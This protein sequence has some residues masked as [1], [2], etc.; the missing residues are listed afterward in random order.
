MRIP[1]QRWGTWHPHSLL[2]EQPLFEVFLVVAGLLRDPWSLRPDALLLILSWGGGF[3]WKTHISHFN[4]SVFLTGKKMHS[5][6][7]VE[8]VI[9]PAL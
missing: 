1:P 3:L 7:H 6:G 8:G 4:A 5:L 2:I 9:E